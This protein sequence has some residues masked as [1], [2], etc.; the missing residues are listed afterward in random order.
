MEEVHITPLAPLPEEIDH[1]EEDTLVQDIAPRMLDA[2]CEAEND[3]G[4]ETL[5][6]TDSEPD[7]REKHESFIGGVVGMNVSHFNLFKK[8]FKF[9]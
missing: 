8:Y 9:T 4:T 3:S 6:E 5:N 1:I 7:E 2:S